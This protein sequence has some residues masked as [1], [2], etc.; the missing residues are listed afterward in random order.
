MP[1]LDWLFSKM[2]AA[3]SDLA[4]DFGA[5]QITGMRAAVD[6]L[7]PPIA[8]LMGFLPAV[9]DSARPNVAVLQVGRALVLACLQ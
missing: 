6:E 8:E 4:G 2:N 9:L 3:L 7:L 5:P 1:K